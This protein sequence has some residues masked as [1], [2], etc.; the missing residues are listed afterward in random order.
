VLTR[1]GDCFARLGR[2]DQ[3]E[4]VFRRAVAMGYDKAA[5]L[6]LARLCRE[7][8][9]WEEALGHYRTVLD[10]TPGD[11]RTIL[12]MGDALLQGQ[13]PEPARAWMASQLAAHPGSKGLEGALER[14]ARGGGPARTRPAP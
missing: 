10:R 2:L 7:R 12:L 5:L 1:A 8:G 11:A 6:G 4:A 9:K 3:A 14:L 13:G